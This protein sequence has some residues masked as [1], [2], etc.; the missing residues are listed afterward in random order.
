M[1]SIGP[2]PVSE[3]AQRQMV[4]DAEALKPRLRGWLHLGSLPV[5]VVAGVVLVV[6][7]PTGVSRLGSAAFA[8]SGVL[9]FGAS[10]AYHRGTWSPR[11]H[12]VMRRLDHCGIFVL[13]AGTCS[14]YSLILLDGPDRVALTVTV[15]VGAA[16]GILSRM[17]WPQAP[18]W[19]SPPLYIALGLA[20]ALF[21]PALVGGARGLGGPGVAALLLAAIGGVLY[22]TGAAVYL[23]QR[24]DPWPASFGFHE[25]FHVFTVLAFM[26]HF[27]GIAVLSSS[28]T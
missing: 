10:A 12:L 19:V 11:A 13:I 20:P 2:A 18:R 5:A 14:A 24:P 22:I 7:S 25:V 16:L 21:A 27:V 6:L 9:L 4:L 28:L 15:V 1:F 3:R 8:V 23:L 26:C 17:R